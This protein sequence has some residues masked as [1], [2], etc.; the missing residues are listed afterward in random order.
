MGETRAKKD[1]SRV[2]LA[3]C[4]TNKIRS[5]FLLKLGRL[6]TSIENAQVLENDLLDISDSVI[7]VVSRFLYSNTVERKW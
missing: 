5:W 3:L 4:F 7:D 1:A 2:P 6:L